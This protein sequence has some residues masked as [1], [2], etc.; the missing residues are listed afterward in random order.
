MTNIELQR[1]LQQH[2]PD[3]PVSIEL[4]EYEGGRVTSTIADSDIFVGL[5]FDGD[6]ILLHNDPVYDQQPHSSK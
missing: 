1:L 2:P 5:V 4:D 6:E 3:W